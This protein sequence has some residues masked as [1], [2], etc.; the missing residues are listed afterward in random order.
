MNEIRPTHYICEVCG[1]YF[2]VVTDKKKKHRCEKCGQAYL[3][4]PTQYGGMSV[5]DGG[6]AE[7]KEG[8]FKIIKGAD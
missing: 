1:Y 3:L 6:D 4:V 8:R 5:M 7:V 2:Y